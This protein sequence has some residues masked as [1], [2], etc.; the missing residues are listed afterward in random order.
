MYCRLVII[1]HARNA[2]HL[3]EVFGHVEGAEEWN[4]GDDHAASASL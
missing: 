1:R 4:A 3:Y 2:Q